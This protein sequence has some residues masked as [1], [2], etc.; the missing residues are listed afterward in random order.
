MAALKRATLA[1]L[2]RWRSGTYEI[3]PKSEVLPA[4]EGKRSDDVNN[5]LNN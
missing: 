4:V 2:A 3:Q 5:A 1:P